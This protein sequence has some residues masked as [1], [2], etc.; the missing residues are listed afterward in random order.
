VISL[1]VRRR[2]TLVIGVVDIKVNGAV[3]VVGTRGAAVVVT[4]R[5]VIVLAS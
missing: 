1:A 5:T 4:G 2:A 3:G